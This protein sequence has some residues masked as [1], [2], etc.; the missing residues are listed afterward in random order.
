MVVR[1]ITVARPAFRTLVKPSVSFLWELSAARGSLR[2]L[3]HWRAE[4]VGAAEDLEAVAVATG[5]DTAVIDEVV[6]DKGYHS[7][8]VLVDLAALD[9][10]TYIAEPIAGRV[11]GAAGRPRATRSMRTAGGFAG[12]AAVG[13]SDAGANA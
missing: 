10:R 8:Q 6:A 4:L 12:P 11:T 13:C 5:G 1:P 7:N 3:H 2:S 9:L